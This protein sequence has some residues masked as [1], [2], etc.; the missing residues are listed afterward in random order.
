MPV[1][2]VLLIAGYGGH[3][4][5][6]YAIGYYLVKKGVELDIL[7]PKGYD[8]VKEKLGG[9]GEVYEVTLPRRPAEPLY[10][11]IAR[12]F[13]AFGESVKLCRNNKYPVVF[14]SGSNFSIPPSLVCWLKDSRI[15]TI[16][17]VARFTRR[18]RATNILYRLGA[19]VF[20]HWDEQL[21]LYRR[22]IVA[23][24][25]YEPAI[26]ES[27]DEG[28]ILVTTG[29]FGHKALFDMLDRLEPGRK[30][31]LQTGDVDPEPYK[32]RHPEWIVFQYTSDI[33]KWIAGAS[34]VITHYPGTTALTARLSYSKPVIMV[35]SPRHKLAAPRRDS[36]T[37]ARKLGVI[38]LDSIEPVSLEEA[39][40]EAPLLKL[41]K[42]RNGGEYIAEYI[43]RILRGAG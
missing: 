27:R 7:V 34:L 9:L 22:G 36:L 25:V 16:E 20:L 11:G 3:S 40:R 6:A 35:Y 31:V 24:P 18:S 17:D 33:H 5:F 37:L 21:Q 41:P 10:K 1:S 28:Y 43:M 4:G 32:R 23:G 8:W 15:L 12:W 38:Y 13:Q 2:R 14:A 19:E 42:Y 26:Y 39:I 29:T 30:I